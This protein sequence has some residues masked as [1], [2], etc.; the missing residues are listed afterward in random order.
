M[1]APLFDGTAAGTAIS[2]ALPGTAG[3]SIEA[4]FR[5]ADSTA[6]RT[7]YS[8]ANIAS[9][10][11]TLTGTGTL[12]LGTKGGTVEAT[13][14][15][16][17]DDDA[18]HHVVAL[19]YPAVGGTVWVDG[20]VDN[21][22]STAR[23]F[24]A[25]GT[26]YIGH[27]GGS[28]YFVGRMQ[29][30]SIYQTTLGTSVAYEHYVQGVTYAPENLFVEYAHD[31]RAHAAY[32]LTYGGTAAGWRYSSDPAGWE[33]GQVQFVF[34]DDDV[35]AGFAS[36][37]DAALAGADAELE[38]R[39]PIDSAEFSVLN[40]GGWKPGQT[41]HIRDTY[42]TGGAWLTHVVQSVEGEVGNDTIQYRVL[43]GEAPRSLVQA[44]AAK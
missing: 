21:A 38:R 32:A 33:A 8:G 41:I 13:S 44:V 10:T 42:L 27:G 2:T 40:L 23:T 22:T 39:Q 34:T 18:W 26:A 43:T 14:A 37:D 16:S 5:A 1:L 20:T 17:W 4:W 28:A 24:A 36:V 30:L 7:L 29:H 3:F 12:T 19:H 6:V 15:T 35:S 25:P 31:N 11:L 9:P